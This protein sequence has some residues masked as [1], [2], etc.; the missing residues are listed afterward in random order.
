M[1]D[2]ST[3]AWPCRCSARPAPLASDMGD[4]DRLQIW[5]ADFNFLRDR[6]ATARTVVSQG[7]DPVALRSACVGGD[8][9]A[10]GIGEAV[11]ARWQARER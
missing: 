6:V 10:A 8:E 5:I 4:T 1:G 2:A 7:S 9:Q 3:S 11:Q